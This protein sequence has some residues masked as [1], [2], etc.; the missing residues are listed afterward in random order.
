MN[1]FTSLVTGGCGGI[2]K[3]IVE[4][5]LKRGDNVIVFD[6][7][8]IENELV[9]DLEKLN[10]VYFQV[11]ISNVESIKNAFT[12]L[13]DFLKSKKITL[14]LLVNNAGVTHDNLAIRMTEHDWDFVLNVNLKGTFFC[15]QQAIKHMMKNKKG[16]IINLSSIVASSGNPGQA[17]YAASKAGINVLT[18]TL[19]QEYSARNILINAIAP[20]FIKTGMAEKLSKEIKNFALDRISLKRFGSPDDV[21]NLIEF[22]SSGK[23]DYITG[24]IIDLNGGMF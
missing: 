15:S 1:N 13:F 6:C 18:K 19:A 12:N 8:P 9:K 17:N 2:G 11:D 7:L 23:A 20:G 4:Q 5:L 16:Y 24:Q 3:S 10:V 22:L 21:A 14:D